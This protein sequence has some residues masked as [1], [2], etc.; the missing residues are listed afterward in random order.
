[1][2]LGGHGRIFFKDNWLAT[3]CRLEV[4]WYPL[5]SSS[6]IE[7]VLAV[8]PGASIQAAQKS[9]HCHHEV[10][11]YFD[12]R[13]MVRS[14]AEFVRSALD[15]GS[16][17]IIV[18]TKSHRENLAKE[19][20]YFGVDLIKASEQGRFVSLDAASTLAQFMVNDSPDEGLFRE[21]I[22]TVI[23]VAAAASS[24]DHEKVVIF[25]EMVTLLWQGGDAPSAIRLEQL[26]N[27]ISE[28]HS[29]RLRC[30]YPLASF[31]RQVHTEW[32]SQICGEHSLVIPAEGYTDLPDET[33]RLRTVAR[34]QQESPGYA[35]R[36][37]G[38]TTQ[39]LAVET[40]QRIAAGHGL[41]RNQV[42]ESSSRIAEGACTAFQSRVTISRDSRLS[43]DRWMMR[44]QQRK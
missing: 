37:F 2:C 3:S 18:A 19:L 22:G 33:E 35:R 26:W 6:Q 28:T 12:D 9:V 30:G 38:R 5:M 39:H 27:L 32:F 4:A 17:T 21:V 42:P 36:R 15:A 43:R 29:F 23:S 24:N 41:R 44:L 11:F 7:P 31:D 13:F 25:G 14:L 1:M 16:S 8:C 20:E 40:S 34:L 10:Q